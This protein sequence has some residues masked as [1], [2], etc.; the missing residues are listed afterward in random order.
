MRL[1]GCI[2]R[3]CGSGRIMP[4]GI[5]TWKPGFTFFGIRLERR[6]FPRVCLYMDNLDDC[7]FLLSEEGRRAIVRLH[8]EGVIK[9]LSAL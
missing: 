3:G 6:C 8:V 9:Y 5:R 1:R 7:R 4:M 2:F